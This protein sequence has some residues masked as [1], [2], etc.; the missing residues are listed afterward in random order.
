MSSVRRLAISARPGKADS[1]AAVHLFSASIQFTDFADPRAIDTDPE[2]KRRDL[3]DD[4]IL[5][6]HRRALRGRSVR[7][8]THGPNGSDRR[9][10]NHEGH[11]R[12]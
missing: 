9:R 1:T 11:G 8:K 6:R 2:S 4:V 3:V 7:G 5:L 12:L 10:K